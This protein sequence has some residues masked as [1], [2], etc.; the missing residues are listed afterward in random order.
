MDIDQKQIE[1]WLNQ[2]QNGDASAKHLLLDHYRPLVIRAVSDVCKRYIDWHQ[3]EASVG[4]LALNEAIERYDL[5]EGKSFENYVR[6]IV[7][8]RLTDHFRSEKRKTLGQVAWDTGEEDEYESSSAEIASSM[9]LYA[10]QQ[11]SQSL[12][13]ELM[14]YDEVLQQYGILL[15][16]LEGDSPDH[17][18]TRKRLIRIAKEFCCR[19]DHLQHLYKTKQLPLKAMLEWADV[20]RKTLERNRKYIIAIILI[21]SSSEFVHIRSTISFAEVGE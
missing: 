21:Y 11:V 13:D 7:K 14:L 19:P 4:L 12:A 8:S 9:E 1:I 5:S 16:S 6:L 2:A 17:Q 20:S 10:E 15:E 3:D 18:D